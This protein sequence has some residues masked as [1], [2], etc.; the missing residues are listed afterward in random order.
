MMIKR[1]YQTYHDTQKGAVLLIAMIMLVIMLIIGLAAGKLVQTQEAMT[2]GFYDRSLAFQA[3]ETALREGENHVMTFEYVMPGGFEAAG[4]GQG[5]VYNC[6][7]DEAAGN[8][9]DMVP[10]PY[11]AGR[12]GG[13]GWHNISGNAALSD[14]NSAIPPQFYIDRIGSATEFA[15]GAPQ[16]ASSYQYG[17]AVNSS[18]FIIYRITARSHNPSAAA[19]DGRSLVVLQSIIRRQ[20]N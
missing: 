8:E 11:G 16:D 2:G 9:C 6:N 5:D 17:S 1:K 3:A 7:P 15:G 4:F 20:V 18:L 10:D 12:G 14:L 19:A 13:V